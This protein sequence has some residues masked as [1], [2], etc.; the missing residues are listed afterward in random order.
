MRPPV[1]L[2]TAAPFLTLY[3]PTFRRPQALARLLDSVGQQT[4]ADDLEHLVV[5]DHVG[6]GLVGGLFGRLPWYA[7]AVRGRY[8]NLLCDDDVLASE[9][10]VATVRAFAA[11]HHHPEVIIARVVKGATALPAGDPLAEPVC[12]QVD[13]TSYIVRGDIWQK[14]VRD[15]G[16]RY[17]GD[18]DH[19]LALY[20]AGYAHA[21]CDV[22][23]AVGGQSH[24]RPE[25]GA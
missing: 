4:A 15:Y 11:S 2:P 5:P 9:T 3:T 12:G 14:H 18:F 19:A 25:G 13:L 24:G 1:P 21:F 7:P 16:L 10:V 20:R 17:E 22:L 23:W 6:Y 8:V